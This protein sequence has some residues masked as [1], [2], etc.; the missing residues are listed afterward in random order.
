MIRV[1]HAS[2]ACVF[3]G[4]RRLRRGRMTPPERAYFAARWPRQIEQRRSQ[5]RASGSPPSF[6][7]EETDFV[8][9]NHGKVRQ[10]G[11]VAQR[12]LALRL[13]A[14]TRHAGTRCRCPAISRPTARRSRDAVGGPARALPDLAEDPLPAAADRRARRARVG[15]RRRAAAGGGGDRR[16]PGGG[17]RPR[18]GRHLR[19]RADLA[20]LRE[21]RRP[22]QLARD[23][24]FNLQWSL[25]HRADK[26]VKARYA[27]FAWDAA[28]FAHKMADARERLALISRPPQRA[29]ARQVPRVPRAVGDGGDAGAAGLGRLLGPRA[30]DQAERARADARRARRSTRA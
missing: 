4:R 6:A 15:A 24:R 25:Y 22:A 10:A 11:T 8:R 1:G 17:R 18:P 19:R 28:A 13:I 21:L 27:G 20:R 14:G 5:R 30:R 16:D 7:A 2:P 26:A 9:M 23:D 12:Y 29:R 3:S